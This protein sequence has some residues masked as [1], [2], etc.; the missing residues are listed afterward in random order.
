[1]AFQSLDDISSKIPSEEELE[2]E[3]KKKE[4]EDYLESTKSFSGLYNTVTTPDPANPD[5]S[6]FERL[7]KYYPSVYE[8]G[9][10]VLRATPAI[11]NVINTNDL[12]E[13]AK[14][15]LG[16]KKKK[17]SS[18]I[19]DLNENLNTNKESEPSNISSPIEQPE[20]DA[21][22]DLL[23]QQINT[24]HSSGVPTELDLGED[25]IHATQ[26]I[27]DAESRAR[28][29]ELV[30]DLGRSA[31][32]IGTSMGGTRPIAQD[33][34]KE[35]IEY[36][37]GLVGKEKERIQAEKDDPNSAKSKAYR[38]LMSKL[39]INI[40]GNP[41]ASDLEKIFP[42]MVNIH[43]AEEGRKSRES[44]GRMNLAAHQA[45]RKEAQDYK[46]DE[47][48][49]SRFAQ[50]GQ[51][52]T[53]EKASS[54]SSFGTDAKTLQAVQNVKALLAGRNVDDIDVREQQEMA[55]VLDRVLAQGGATIAGTRELTP[56]TARG[57]IAKFMEY[58]GNKRQS[59]HAGSFM[60]QFQKA[61]NREE[62]T[63]QDRII[64]TQKKLLAPYADLKEKYPDRWDLIL[65]Q[66]NLPS[67]V[68]TTK[69]QTSGAVTQKDPQ[70]DNYAKTH[71]MSYEQ[72][73]QL[74]ENR[75]KKSK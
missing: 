60:K 13:N 25:T 66:H 45:Q 40:K 18:P 10:T 24:N 61:F 32:L 65:T 22:G 49:N 27:K 28:D 11:G 37:R 38:Q 47:K 7:H 31:E 5:L 14:E 52:I 62:Q 8:M 73:F 6:S 57:D 12:Y 64:Q 20:V 70:I 2:L 42:Q 16:K 59:A 48:S 51:L 68:L 35:N 9:K 29:I 3:R 50:M 36:A 1:M 71:N 21:V 72:A 30:N 39:N 53:A 26:R 33:I 17:N 46:T 41:S 23:K 43:E 34:F 19:I 75:K 58:I 44:L 55:R 4:E 15:F 54:R 74:I 67:D 69:N 56:H 63:A